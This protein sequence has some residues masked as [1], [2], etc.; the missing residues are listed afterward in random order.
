MR[1]YKKQIPEA[2]PKA[3]ALPEDRLILAGQLPIAEFI[4]GVREDIEAFAAELG[5]TFIRC[6][7]ESEI[8]QKLGPWGQ[9]QIH[10]HGHQPGYVIF[11]GRKINLQ[12]PR[13][14]SRQK[15]EVALASYR[16]FQRDG[17]LQRAEI[18][19]AHV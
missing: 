13:L 17:R 10:R 18:G 12:R 8:E 16:A 6:V 9:Q 5:L 1:T 11:G 15:Q 14:R 2:K 19:R 4:T 3:A 7:M